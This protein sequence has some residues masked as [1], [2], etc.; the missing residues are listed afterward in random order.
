MAACSLLGLAAA[1]LSRT[2]EAYDDGGERPEGG[3][4]R[5]GCCGTGLCGV[6]LRVELRSGGEGLLKNC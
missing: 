4:S 1:W 5:H 2:A 3:E 6:K